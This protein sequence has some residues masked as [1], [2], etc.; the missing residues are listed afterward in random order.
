[1]ALRMRLAGW[2][3][4]ALAAATAWGA[5]TQGPAAVLSAKTV[6][7]SARA[8]VEKTDY[9]AS[10]RLVRVEANGTRVNTTVN[11]EAH[12]FPDGL[13]LL[14]A[15]N[16][17]GTGQVRYLLSM[18]PE[19]HTAIEV[20]RQG[21]QAPSRLPVEDWGRGVA[22]TDFAVEDFVN[23]QF[24]WARQTVLPEQKYGARMCFV[25]RSEPG[26]GQ[27]SHYAQ[28][29]TWL[30]EKTGAPVYVETRAKSDAAQKQFVFY[31]LEQIGG[32]WTS[33]QVEAKTVGQAGSSILILE[34]GSPHAHLQRKDFNPVAF[35]MP[36]K[37]A[38]R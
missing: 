27:P 8:A 37:A 15:V 1:M 25:V 32:T 7:A 10:G 21:E 3:G 24:F 31:D 18:D 36:W 35:P 26:A 23:G 2:A 11:L 9:R 6:V 14:V 33:R 38:E 12:W 17:T 28:V 20:L 34:H 16:G 30:D 4:M 19:G 13:R 22:G 29:T 5:Q